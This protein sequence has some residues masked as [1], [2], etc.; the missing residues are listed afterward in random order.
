MLK[1][2]TVSVVQTKKMMK[3]LILLIIGLL[4]VVLAVVFVMSG[5]NNRGNDGANAIGEQALESVRVGASISGRVVL[6]GGG[7]VEGARIRAV[8]VG[9]DLAD[10]S[11]A[12]ASEETE[13][14]GK[15]EVEE[16]VSGV[17]GAFAFDVLLPGTYVLDVV[18]AEGFV[19]AGPPGIG[20]REVVVLDG[21]AGRAGVSGVEL[22][23]HRPGMVS[24]RVTAAGKAI[25]DA[26]LS[27]AYMFAEGVN[28][29]A[30]EPFSLGEV[31]KTAANGTFTFENVAPGRLRVMVET[32]DYAFAE[33][34]E[35]FLRGGET[36]NG[37]LIDLVESGSIVGRVTTGDTGV[38]AEVV[39]LGSAELGRARRV[40]ADLAGNFEF[41]N[42]PVG[43]FSMRVQ[44]Q[45]YRSVLLDVEVE[46]GAQTR[47]DVA[48]SAA[49]GIFGRVVDGEKN[50][51]ARA[52]VWFRSGSG[53]GNPSDPVVR[54]GEDGTFEWQDPPAGNWLAVAMSPFH[55]SSARVAARLDQEIVLELGG[56]GSAAGRVVDRGGRA[57]ATYEI[58]V[59]EFKEED[60]EGAPYY[61]S[62]IGRLQVSQADGAFAFEKL[63]PGTYRF[64]VQA[65]GMAPGFSE[66]VV[67]RAGARREGIE[68]RLGEGATVRG[69]VR[70]AAGGEPISGAVVTLM[71][72]TSE[73]SARMARTDAAGNYEL[74]GVPA[75]RH[76]LRVT[77]AEYLS[78]FSS[79]LDIP[80][81]GVLERDMRLLV[82]ERGQAFSFHGIGAVLQSGK[83]GIEVMSIM[84]GTPA[85]AFGLQPGDA[86]RAVD[87]ER[88]SE[89]DLRRVVEMIRG[90]EGAPVQIEIDREGEGRM[91]L[92]IERGR[93]VV[94]QGG[95]GE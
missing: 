10:G 19:R 89:M 59:E 63:R 31:V 75:G 11:G 47:R 12:L 69:V 39:L 1:V 52:M 50:P 71:E 14:I 79:G 81:S 22:L 68:I 13:N 78:E 5:K 25:K 80:S 74:R 34:G 16:V 35:V 64:R 7:G 30:L 58:A 9:G 33:S 72:P 88:T 92:N 18:S 93:V 67:V 6:A 57:V 3:R 56:S 44:A 2:C 62:E 66:R 60:G 24:G 55:E 40:T 61:R 43:R 54:T 20:G 86:I 15:S 27:L 49:A 76:S 83:R 36:R 48:L 21:S 29:G 23:L 26:R 37:V 41:L 42:V 73:F 77:H 90:E 91:T 65:V 70:A 4:L 17:D 87:R 46:D 95:A 45:G 53:P 85:A 94:Q 8:I 38:A 32:D 84:D 51:V 82:R 28:G